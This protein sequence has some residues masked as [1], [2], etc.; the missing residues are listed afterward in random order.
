VAKL[1]AE[2]VK[3]L[4]KIP[5][6]EDRPSKIKGGSA[7]FYK[8]KEVAHFHHDNEIDVRLTR[9]V[10]RKEGLHHP[11]DSKMHHQRTPASEW[12]EIRFTKAAHVDEVVRLFKLALE[13]Y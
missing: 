11:S 7:I 6:L 8:N 4:E 3:R 5:G 2:L 12:I 13:Q 10:I 9:K 1:R